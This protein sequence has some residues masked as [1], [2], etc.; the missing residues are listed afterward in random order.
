MSFLV[1][2]FKFV[3]PKGKDHD[4]GINFSR[5]TTREETMGIEDEVVDVVLFTIDVVPPWTIDIV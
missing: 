3:V 1:F 5:L 2:Y 4:L